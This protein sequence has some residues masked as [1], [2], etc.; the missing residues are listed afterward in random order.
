ML[1]GAQITLGDVNEKYA[2]FVKVAA[3]KAAAEKRDAI[4][5]KL[6]QAELEIVDRLS[7]GG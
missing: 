6:S 5:W 3:E 2:A 1:K 4:R 7:K